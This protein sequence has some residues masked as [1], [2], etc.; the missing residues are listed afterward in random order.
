MVF[1]EG[2]SGIL[3]WVWSRILLEFEENL[4]WIEWCFREQD[5]MLFTECLQL[6]LGVDVLPD[7]FHVVPVVDDA[8]FHGVADREEA[9][10]LLGLWAHK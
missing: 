10:V 8:V 7:P 3:D 5:W 4:P 6:V 1:F 2:L 9:A